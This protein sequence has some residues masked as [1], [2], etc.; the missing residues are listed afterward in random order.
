MQGGQVQK[1][2]DFSRGKWQSKKPIFG[3]GDDY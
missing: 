1:I 2:P 3:M